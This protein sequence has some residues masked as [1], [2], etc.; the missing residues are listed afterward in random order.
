M[1]MKITKSIVHRLSVEMS[2]GC[3]IMREYGDSIY[4]EPV[5]L[6]K[7]FPCEAHASDPSLSVL[8]FIMTELLDK[9]A[10]EA[11][12][13]PP[14]PSTNLDENGELRTPITNKPSSR[15]KINR[16]DGVPTRPAQDLSSGKLI[17]QELMDESEGGEVDPLDQFLNQS[18]P[19][20][21]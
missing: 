5:G 13:A 20:E 10:E 16:T 4:K 18:D 17:D 21:A 7:S 15:V 11:K 9:E 14:A 19:T 1:A 12:E 3:S 8:I 2:C 6:H